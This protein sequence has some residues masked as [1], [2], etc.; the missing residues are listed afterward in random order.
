MGLLTTA[1]TNCLFTSLVW[2]QPFAILIVMVHPVCSHIRVLYL[3]G[4]PWRG[5]RKRWHSG[6]ENLTL[7]CFHSVF[8]FKKC[9]R[10]RLNEGLKPLVVTTLITLSFYTICCCF[11]GN[12]VQLQLLLKSQAQKYLDSDTILMIWP[13]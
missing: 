6:I 11:C 12:I 8:I 9:K 1:V 2:T 4:K 13:L 5:P 10:M 7:V 3:S